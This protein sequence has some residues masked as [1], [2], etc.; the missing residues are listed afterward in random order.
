MISTSDFKKGSTKILWN[1][2]P[3]L[4]IDYQLVKPGK[5]GT[6]LRTK[7]RNLLTGRMLEETFRSAEKFPEPD[8]EQVN[9]QYLYSS[10]DM[11]HFMNKEDFEQVDLSEDQI[12][13][14]KNYLKEGEAYSVMS[15]KGRV[16]SV[17]PPMFMILTITETM[18]GVKGDTAQGGSKPA[19]LESGLVISV[20]LFLQEGDKIKID[21]R[22]DK[23]IE[24][25]N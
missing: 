23:Y 22:E 12:V 14:A 7:M 6:Y 21:T 10:D 1:N 18:P 24:R 13:G 20:P 16:V 11:Y 3:W 5:G 2:E 19:T 4:V 25:V 15:F 17:E 8:V 9:M